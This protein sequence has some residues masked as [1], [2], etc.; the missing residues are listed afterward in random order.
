MELA[1]D[2]DSFRRP[3]V[4]KC[5]SSSSRGKSMFHDAVQCVF[6]WTLLVEAVLSVFSFFFYPTLPLGFLTGVS[7]AN[8]IMIWLTWPTI[9]RRCLTN[10]LVFSLSGVVCGFVDACGW[11]RRSMRICTANWFPVWRWCIFR[12]RVPWDVVAQAVDGTKLGYSIRLFKL[13]R[14][15][16][17]MK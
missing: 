9:W 6:F 14:R 4:I 3:V 1:R 5:A 16:R 8:L 13:G 15:K 17:W 2:E 10:F 7:M 11:L 12:R